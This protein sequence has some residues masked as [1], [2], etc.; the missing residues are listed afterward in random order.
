MLSKQTTSLAVITGQRRKSLSFK[1]ARRGRMMILMRRM[2]M[3]MIKA[4]ELSCVLCVISGLCVQGM[5][6]EL[7]P[8]ALALTGRSLIMTSEQIRDSVSSHSFSLHSQSN[9]TV[10][11]KSNIAS[12]K[13][14]FWSHIIIYLHSVQRWKTS[15]I[16][17]LKVK[18]YT[19]CTH[20]HY[21]LFHFI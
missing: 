6:A 19:T 15:Q 16:H 11:C 3:M 8:L 5:T 20:Q 14:T 21:K 2:M 13:W 18:I 10:K 9:R 1:A 7:C 4:S 17:T 12:V